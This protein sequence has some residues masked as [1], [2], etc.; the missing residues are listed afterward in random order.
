MHDPKGYLSDDHGFTVVAA[1]AV[2]VSR[3]LSLLSSSIDDLQESDDG[4]TNKP[5]IHKS[6]KMVSKNDD[7][8]SLLGCNY[9]T[10]VSL[11][12]CISLS[13]LFST[14]GLHVLRI[15][16]RCGLADFE[17]SSYDAQAKVPLRHLLI[18]SVSWS[19]GRSVGV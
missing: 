10:L 18:W 4:L 9:T 19:V 13:R 2:V 6:I 16:S 17:F 1:A 3:R 8:P 11:S 15:R 5:T 14:R 7:G 12:V